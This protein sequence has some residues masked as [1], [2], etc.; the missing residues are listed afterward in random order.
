VSDRRWLP[1]IGERKHNEKI[2]R[3]S[4]IA[5]DYKNLPFKF[6]KPKKDKRYTRFECIECS[7][8]L[9]APINTIMCVCHNC[10]KTTKVEK[11]NQD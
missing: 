2:H 8:V 1:D 11:L 4:K 7:G 10:K 9:F 3:E 5:D 6:S